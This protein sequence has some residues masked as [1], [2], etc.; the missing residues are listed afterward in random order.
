[1]MGV[2]DWAKKEGRRRGEGH[3]RLWVMGVGLADKK[4]VKGM[5]GLGRLYRVMGNGRLSEGDGGVGGG[6]KC[7]AWCCVV[8]WGTRGHG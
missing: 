4:E 1:M 3:F 8:T 6:V 2:W 7:Q 5:E